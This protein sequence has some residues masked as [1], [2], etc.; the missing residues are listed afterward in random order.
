MK[1][2][3]RQL[4]RSDK[5]EIS[6]RTDKIVR[7]GLNQLQRRVSR[8]INFPIQFSIGTLYTV[9]SSDDDFWWRKEWEKLGEA[10]GEVLIP[11][12]KKLILEVRER[13]EVDEVWAGNCYDY[14]V[15]YF[16][17]L[18]PLAELNPNDLQGIDL[19]RVSMSNLETGASWA[20]IG[21]L[22][23]LENLEWLKVNNSSFE[24]LPLLANLANLKGLDFSG[25]IYF[26]PYVYG[27]SPLS[28]LS[29]LQYLNLGHTRIGN[30]AGLQQLTE[31]RCLDF[32]FVEVIENG[33]ILDADF[34]N[35]LVNLEELYL[36]GVEVN[37]I[38]CL[39]KL[40][41]LRILEISD[42]L[43]SEE[44]IAVLREALPNC[45]IR[46]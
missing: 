11:L 23:G 25:N 30:P 33:G 19:S 10:T 2:E 26:S 12:G 21:Y 13:E 5:G 40:P 7:R 22:E 16:T 6:R 34:L 14:E 41:K 24:E 38:A 37:E 44:E 46:H 20:S 32:S 45:A 15:G 9:D 8:I 27:L 43:Y 42:W 29:K 18:S 17:D 31:L 28:G 4:V 3:N 36:T 1:K 35:K 39:K